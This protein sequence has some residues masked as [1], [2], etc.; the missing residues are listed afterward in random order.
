MPATPLFSTRLL[1]TIPLFVLAA[2]TAR[3]SIAP[4]VIVVPRIVIVPAAIVVAAPFVVPAA[5]VVAAARVLDRLA[6][7]CFVV[8]TTLRHRRL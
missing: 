8:A 7:S 2:T 5:L 1:T 4:S 6:S 3:A